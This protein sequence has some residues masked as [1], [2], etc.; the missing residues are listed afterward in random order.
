MVIT[1]N[2]R[3]TSSV[4]DLQYPNIRRLLTTDNLDAAAGE[5]S[6][7]I[8]QQMP[9]NVKTVKQKKVKKPRDPNA[10]KRPLTAFF[11]FLKEKRDE[12]TKQLPPDVKPGEVQ[13]RMTDKWNSMAES[14][15][16]VLF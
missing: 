4:S 1:S 3:G 9:A 2:E 15:Q 16:K 5:T 14:E 6:L 8:Y 12:T 10:P 7:P 11:L 13:T